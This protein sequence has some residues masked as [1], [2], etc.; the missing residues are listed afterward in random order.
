MKESKYPIK[1]AAVRMLDEG[2]ICRIIEKSLS[3]TIKESE[4]YIYEIIYFVSLTKCF[5][6]KP[7]LP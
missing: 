7:A 4:S 5:V 3:K 6:T 1:V 2:H